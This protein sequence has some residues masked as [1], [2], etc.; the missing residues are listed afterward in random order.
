MKHPDHEIDRKQ[1]LGLLEPKFQETL[2][3]LI[4]QLKEESVKGAEQE[5][6]PFDKYKN[7]ATEFKKLKGVEGDDAAAGKE[8]SKA[9]EV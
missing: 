5:G 7:Q 4:N 1:I 9:E 6:D 2:T 3:A 8:E